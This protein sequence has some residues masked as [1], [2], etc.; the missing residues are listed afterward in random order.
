[1]PTKRVKETWIS[2]AF[3]AAGLAVAAVASV[4]LS[5]GGR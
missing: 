2:F 5:K 1:V 3:A 4:V